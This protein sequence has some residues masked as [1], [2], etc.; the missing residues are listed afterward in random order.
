MSL[1]A[2]VTA[3]AEDANAQAGLTISRESA[4]TLCASLLTKRFLILTGLSGSGKTKLA[5]AFARWITSPSY[6]VGEAFRPG[7]P[8][9]GDQITYYVGA[10]DSLA[11]EFWNNPD[12]REATV[13]TLPLAMIREWAAH[14]QQLEL[15]RTTSAREIREAV[16][17]HSRYS[18]QL[19]S[20]ETHLKAAAFALLEHQ[21]SKS[22]AYSLVPVGADWTGNENILGYPD[23]LDPKRFVS[24]SALDLI[25]AARA[26][27]QVPHF[28]I[29]DEMNLSHV[30][31]YFAD[32]LSALESAESLRLHGDESRS[33]NGRSVPS[34]LNRLP[35][36]LFVIGTV[37]VDETTYMFSPKVLDRANV[38]EFRVDG[39][40]MQAYLTASRAIRLEPL[41][42]RGVS[43]ALSFLESATAEATLD[44]ALRTAIKDE[45][46]LF[47]DALSAHGAEFGYRTAHEA[48]RFAHFYSVCGGSSDSSEDMVRRAMDRVI[49]QRFLPKLHG[50]RVKVG[51]MLRRLWH[52]CVEQD[53][54]LRLSDSVWQ[55]AEPQITP[56]ASAR[57]PHSA[58]KIAR[59]WRVLQ[60]NGFTSFAEA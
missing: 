29:L 52:L 5:Q 30:E 60:E 20:F 6:D 11:V 4:R 46:M 40:H 49:L 17:D 21:P 43:Y 27:Q 34:V 44:S 2:L 9:R 16:K 58:T 39:A 28:L 37:N 18:S 50:S 41:D 51:P 31:R 7:R 3:F 56:P 23:G 36:N 38:I 8:I 14:I 13:V 32:V 42:G 33:A 10:A 26:N 45:L 48:M 1:D 47:F 59:M 22:A 19:H 55:S 54:A 53:A 24:T 25:L 15:P 12:L 57:Y 35:V